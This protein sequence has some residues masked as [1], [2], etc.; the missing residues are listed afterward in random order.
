MPKSISI[1]DLHVRTSWLPPGSKLSTLCSAAAHKYRGTSEL[2]HDSHAYVA[3]FF[4]AVYVAVS[5]AL[6]EKVITCE[7]GRLAFPL[8]GGMLGATGTAGFCK[9]DVWMGCSA[10]EFEVPLMSEGVCC[11]AVVDNAFSCS[12]FWHVLRWEALLSAT[13]G[14]LGGVG[15]MS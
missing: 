1:A 11:L 2:S 4:D 13:F 14:M 7:R 6:A 8:G 12:I 15:E 3:P 10:V 9:A 5:M